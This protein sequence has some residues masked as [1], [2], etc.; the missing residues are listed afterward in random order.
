MLPPGDRWLPRTR[1]ARL[2]PR[3]EHRA[4]AAY[5][6]QLTHIDH[7]IGRFYEYL[8][9]YKLLDNTM[10]IFCS[11]HGEMLGDHDLWHKALGYSGSAQ[12]PF[13]IKPADSM[14]LAGDRRVAE[15]IELRDIMPTLLDVAGAPIPE[16]VDGLSLMPLL[17]GEEV[18]WRQYVHGEHPG[19]ELSNQYITD[20][21]YKLIW[22]SQ[23]GVEQ[24]FDIESDR[25][26]LYDL[27]DDPTHAEALARMRKALAAELAGREEGY[28]DGENLTVGCTPRAVLSHILPED[29]R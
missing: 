2:D 23:T 1:R 29:E 28:S 19:G 15:P 13:F 21:K 11:D 20:G 10:F 8:S 24:L 16:T 18:E 4:R 25:Q 22:Y 17:R 6:A 5:Y 9:D 26:E 12:V 3:A 7:Q 14:G 27:A